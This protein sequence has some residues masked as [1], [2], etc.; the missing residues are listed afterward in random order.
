MAQLRESTEL[1]VLEAKLKIFYK[2]CVAYRRSRQDPAFGLRAD[3]VRTELDIPESVFAKA[4]ETFVDVKNQAI[5]EMLEK[6]G[7]RYL[8]LGESARHNLSD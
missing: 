2:L 3:D 6:N 1:A 8:R 7:V 5:V 4:L